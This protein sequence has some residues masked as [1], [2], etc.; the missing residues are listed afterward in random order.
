MYTKV[1]IRF[2]RETIQSEVIR[3]DGGNCLLC[4]AHGNDVH[5]VV[6][7]SRFGRSRADECFSMRN[8]ALLCRACHRDAHTQQSR[9][10]LFFV[11]SKL[12]GY[13]YA[14]EPFVKY[15]F[16]EEASENGEY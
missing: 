12:Y 3:R 14:D 7:R 15:V 4:G 8:S 13:E 1:E 9:K 5:E 11:L 10:T 2:L 6:P 16:S